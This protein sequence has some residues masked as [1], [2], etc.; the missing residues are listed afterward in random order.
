[1]TRKVIAGFIAYLIIEEPYFF[2]YAF[3]KW[4]AYKKQQKKW[5]TLEPGKYSFHRTD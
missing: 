1:M 2:E 3:H 4:L 5:K